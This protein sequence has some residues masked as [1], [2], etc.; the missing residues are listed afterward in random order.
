MRLEGTRNK[1]TDNLFSQTGDLDYFAGEK[2][3]PS[4]KN[5]QQSREQ[6]FS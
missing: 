1:K 3:V 4:G 6:L 2:Q 5:F